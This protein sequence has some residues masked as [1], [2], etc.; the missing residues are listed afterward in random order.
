MNWTVITIVGPNDDYQAALDATTPRLTVALRRPG[1]V[2]S[3]GPDPIVAIVAR[4][5]AAPL[6]AASDFLS[7]AMSAYAADLRI[8][9]DLAD[10]GWTRDIT[11]LVPVADITIWAVVRQRL[12]AFL[13][14]LTGDRWQIQFRERVPLVQPSPPKKP[15]VI[16]EPGT[17]ACLFSGGLDSLVGVIDLLSTGAPLALVGHHGAGLTNPVQQNVLAG[18]RKNFHALMR[19]FMFYVQPP[20]EHTAGEPSMRSRSVLFLALGIAVASVTGES[21]RLVVAENG[22]ISLN[23]PLTNARIGSSSTRTTHPHVMGA[24]REILAALHIPVQL[25][26]PYRFQTKGE[27]LRNVQAPDTLA[28]LAPLSAS[29]SHP[30]VG[31]YRGITPGTHCGYCVPCII[32]R[33][34]LNAAGMAHGSYDVDILANPPPHDSET[35]R[36]PRAFQMAIARL[37]RATVHETLAAVASTGPLPPPDLEGYARVYR[38]GMNEVSELLGLGSLS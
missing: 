19:E 1:D 18:L 38:R 29:C 24:L 20:K 8:P 14:F 15:K 9:R 3:L 31:R 6:E 34:A 21:A 27:M 25:E 16:L 13:G 12:E 35:S 36:D 37:R 4:T 23:V 32:R 2:H 17:T 22:L 11:L 7:V 28:E 33:A 5:G 10:D 26:L 30:E